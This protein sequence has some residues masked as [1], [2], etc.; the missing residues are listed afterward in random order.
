[1]LGMLTQE[2]ETV[3]WQTQGQPALS[4]KPQEKKKEKKK[5]ENTQCW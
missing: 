2:E 1:M 4:N 3:R 5:L